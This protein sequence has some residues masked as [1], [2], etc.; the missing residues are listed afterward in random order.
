M[1]SKNNSLGSELRFLRPLLVLCGV[2]VHTVQNCTCILCVQT[3][4]CG[5]IVQCSMDKGWQEH[6][7]FV[8]CCSG[9]HAWPLHIQK[10]LSV[11]NFL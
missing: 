1:Y 4:G 9:R 7:R 6:P 11:L 3:Q 8:A 5:D 10:P 2:K